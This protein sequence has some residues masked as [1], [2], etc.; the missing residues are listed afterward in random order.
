MR[1]PSW[2]VPS[3]AERS[4]GQ[5]RAAQRIPPAPRRSLLAR[6]FVLVITLLLL[7]GVFALV[8]SGTEISTG[9]P[10]H[11][12]SHTAVTQPGGAVSH[13][14]QSAPDF[15]LTTLDGAPFHLASQ[16]G[17]VVVLYFVAT[18]CAG[19]EPGSA[20]LAGALQSPKLAGV[21]ALGIDVSTSDRPAD[22]LAFIRS[23]GIAASAPIRWGIDTTGAIATAYHVQALE[24]TVIID[25]QGRIAYR[26][27][28]SLPPDQLAQIVKELA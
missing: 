10:A 25:P 8:H 20:D 1:Q 26:S 3:P 2:H 7:L 9:K 14:V 22:L 16:R 11:S 12:V 19:C 13:A 24:T 17:H 6:G 21:E 15:T 18:I 27:N 23:A 5:D 28:T 4:W